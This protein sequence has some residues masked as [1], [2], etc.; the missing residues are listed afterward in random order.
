M[1]DPLLDAIASMSDDD[2]AFYRRLLE[3]DATN[4]ILPRLGY[5][6]YGWTLVPG[7]VTTYLPNGPFLAEHE[8]YEYLNAR[9]Y[10]AYLYGDGPDPFGEPC[11]KDSGR[12]CRDGRFVATLD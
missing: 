6:A 4:P 9:S 8:C 5:C 12:R 3:M 2:L 10:I 7:L 1:T 11:E